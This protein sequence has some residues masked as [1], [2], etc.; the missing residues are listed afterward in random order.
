MR[1]IWSTLPTKF[2]VLLISM[3]IA[4]IGSG[5]FA[6]FLALYVKDLGADIGQVGIY[7][8]VMAVK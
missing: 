8:T 3:V 4:N 7:F 1:R 6:P 2:K 5:I